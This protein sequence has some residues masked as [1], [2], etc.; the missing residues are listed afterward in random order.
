MVSLPGWL[1]RRQPDPLAASPPAPKLLTF[2]AVISVGPYNLPPG[3]SP[4]RAIAAIRQAVQAMPGAGWISVEHH[5]VGTADGSIEVFPADSCANRSEALRLQVEAVVSA[6]IASIAPVPAVPLPRLRAATPISPDSSFPE[7][8]DGVR[9]LGFSDGQN[10][11]LRSASDPPATRR[12]SIA[13]IGGGAEKRGL[14]SLTDSELLT[15]LLNLVVPSG[16][17]VAGRAVARFGSFAAVLAAPEI[18]LRKLPGLG[19]HSIAAI[20][21]LQ[22]AAL[23][24]SRAAIMDHPLLDGSD[25]LINYLTAVLARESI[26][27]FRILFLDGE[28]RLRADEAQARGTVNHTPVYPRE[29]VRRALELQAASI[30]LVHNH[31]SGDPSPSQDDIEMTTMIEEAAEVVGLEIHD[32][33][34][35]GNGRWLSFRSEGFLRLRRRQQ[36]G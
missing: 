22:A 12:E 8:A 34:I 14:R 2:D 15:H 18:E 23:R 4:N 24:L 11:R 3:L 21:L 35:V 28:G 27:H 31:P 19:T 1:K 36:P 30:I 32:H 17:E 13:P 25:R 20:K 26:E 10:F 29:V 16:A 6:A 9:Q 33:I 5:P 7:P